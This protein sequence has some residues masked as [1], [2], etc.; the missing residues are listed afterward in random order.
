MVKSFCKNSNC[1]L[2]FD[3]NNLKPELVQAII[4][5]NITM[6]LTNEVGRAM[7]KGEYEFVQGHIT[8]T[9]DLD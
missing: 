7:K 3:S 6:I 9:N 8:C 2:D 5:L 4:I 1:D